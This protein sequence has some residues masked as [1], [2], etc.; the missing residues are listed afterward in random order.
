MR[1][2][3]FLT[4]VALILALMWSAAVAWG[5]E[6]TERLNGFRA[7]Q[8]LAGVAYNAGVVGFS[9]ENNR[10]QRERGIGHFVTGGLAQCAAISCGDATSALRMWLN[11]PPHAAI[12]LSPSL[13]SVGFACDG[14]AATVACQ[15]GSTAPALPDPVAVR[16]SNAGAVACRPRRGLFGRV[17]AR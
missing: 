4:M 17:R 3:D 13:G 11:S 2:N 16:A 9:V 14:W 8:G 15:M 7:N 5:D 6:F 1:R 12:L 10:S